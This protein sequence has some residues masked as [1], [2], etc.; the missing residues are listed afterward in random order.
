M[1]GVKR[2]W[3]GDSRAWNIMSSVPLETS[4]SNR[5]PDLRSQKVLGVSPTKIVSKVPRAPP[6]SRAAAHTHQQLSPIVSGWLFI[7]VTV[8]HSVSPRK[9]KWM[10]VSVLVLGG[11]P[12]QNFRI[13][14][15]TM[16][17]EQRVRTR[18][19]NKKCHNVTCVSSLFSWNL[20]LLKFWSERQLSCLLTQ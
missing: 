9:L 19:S 10:A 20:R 16:C 11:W 3:C 14:N 1:I 17:S 7:D 4:C 5:Y 13:F 18:G 8:C 6:V 2:C 15:V 12:W